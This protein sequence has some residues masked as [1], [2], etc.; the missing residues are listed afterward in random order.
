VEACSQCG[1]K[2]STAY[3]EAAR[4]VL[5]ERCYGNL[6]SAR[7]QRVEGIVAKL[8]GLRRPKLDDY[9]Q[10]VRD[11]WAWME[12]DGYCRSMGASPPVLV[13]YCPRCGETMAA[14]FLRRPHA[15]VRLV[16]HGGCDE[17]AVAAALGRSDG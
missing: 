3:S 13:G 1:A 12:R 14:R 2:S 7:E 5:C 17:A 15:E 11:V 10:L 8:P 4:A 9:E 16:C 6:P